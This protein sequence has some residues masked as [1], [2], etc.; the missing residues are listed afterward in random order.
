VPSGYCVI[1]S[2]QQIPF[3]FC[4]VVAFFPFNLRHHPNP[5]DVLPEFSLGFLNV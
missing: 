4:D 5:G 1:V 3:A 2:T